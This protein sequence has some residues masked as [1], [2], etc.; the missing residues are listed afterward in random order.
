M[1]IPAIDAY[2]A[3]LA[4]R[5]TTPAARGNDVARNEPAGQSNKNRANYET[6]KSP[7][8]LLSKKERDFFVKIFPD[9]SSKIE[10]HVLFNR[11]GRLQS[12]NIMKGT[13]IDGRV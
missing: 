11:K 7:D 5:E 1:K 3:Q 12:V 2:T 6:L 4:A 8:N 13:I 9:N 10:N